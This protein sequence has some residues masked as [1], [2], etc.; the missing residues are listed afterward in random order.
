[1]NVVYVWIIKLKFILKIADMFVYVLC[2]F[3]NYNFFYNLF[4]KINDINIIIKIFYGRY[5]IYNIKKCDM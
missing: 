2:V 3:N 5:R 1:M 4:K